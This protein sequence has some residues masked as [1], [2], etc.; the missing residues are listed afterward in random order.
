MMDFCTENDGL[1]TPQV[2]AWFGAK[3]G[4]MMGLVGAGNNFGGLV[5]VNISSILAQDPRY[6]WEYA[7][8]CFACISAM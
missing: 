8:G 6:G 2:G 5:A 1:Y 7:A 4:R 3:R